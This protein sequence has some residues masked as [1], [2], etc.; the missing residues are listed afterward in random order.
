MNDSLSRQFQQHEPII[1]GVLKS[2]Q[3]SHYSPHYDDL[4]QAGRLILIELLMEQDQ[5]AMTAS[6]EATHRYK[7]FLYQRIRWRLIDLLRRDNQRNSYFDD[8]VELAERND[9][10]ATNNDDE[11]LTVS[12][13]LGHTWY[14]L[15]QHLQVYLIAT[16]D[17]QMNLTELAKQL[18][19]SRQTLYNW[20]KQLQQ[21]L[22]D[23][24]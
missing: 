6:H 24:R 7:G 20:R 22:S 16:V 2:L 3:I 10:Q 19:V 14:T 8:S 11:R 12:S 23:Y 18:K 1:Y 17:Y 5:G 4:I 21:R 13:L 9:W 15:P